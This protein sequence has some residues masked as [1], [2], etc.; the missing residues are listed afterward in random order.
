[1]RQ[2]LVCCSKIQRLWVSLSWNGT[3]LCPTQSMKAITIGLW[4]G[5]VG[6]SSRNQKSLRDLQA[7]QVKGGPRTTSEKYKVTDKNGPLKAEWP[8]HKERNGIIGIGLIK[9]KEKAEH[10]LEFRWKDWQRP[11][12]SE[13]GGVT[14]RERARSGGE[15]NSKSNSI[16][17][18]HSSQE[19]HLKWHAN[20][21]R[22]QIKVYRSY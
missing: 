4:M 9:R 3:I 11:K 1:M 14:A 18:L 8:G 17:P 22:W 13:D 5:K 15:A 7:Q 16:C 21:S 19:E 10:H 6:M 2:R 20:L 12:E